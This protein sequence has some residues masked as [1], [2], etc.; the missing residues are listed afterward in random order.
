MAR[1]ARLCIAYVVESSPEGLLSF[2]SGNYISHGAPSHTQR[3]VL[4][5]QDL[6]TITHGAE[7]T[8]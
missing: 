8:R 3:H 1:Q 5:L 6:I 7:K 4:A 2:L